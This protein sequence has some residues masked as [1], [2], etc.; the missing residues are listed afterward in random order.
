[1]QGVL[2]GHLSRLFGQRLLS[3]FRH[4]PV[5]IPLVAVGPGRHHGLFVLTPARDRKLDMETGEIV[6]L[7]LTWLKFLEHF[8]NRVP[9]VAAMEA[10]DGSDLQRGPA[11]KHQQHTGP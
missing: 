4:P 8:G 1:M 2:L 3:T 10:C 6:E 7:K 11:G 5:L 9:C